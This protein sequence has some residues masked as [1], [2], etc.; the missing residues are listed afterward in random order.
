M[1]VFLDESGDSG[2][3]I[4]RG[5][6]R[7]LTVAIVTF[8]DAEQALACDG[9]I[10]SLRTE[11][12]LQPAFE[13]HFS[14]NSERVRH[15]FL[16]AVAAEDFFY[17]AFSLNKDPEKLWGPGFNVK[18]SLYKYVSRL[19]FENAKPYLQDATVVID[20]SGDRHFR[21]QLAAYLRKYVRGE[22]GARMIRK[23]KIQ[24]SSGNNLLQLA[25]YVAGVANRCV[26]GRPD[27]PGYRRYLA[28]HEIT[29]RVWP[30]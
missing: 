11:L 5:S 22:A 26:L 9:R 10:A 27:A 19:V 20:G 3:K 25:D 4:E 1:L 29:M 13:F 17:H 12:G 8:D 16:G 30:T 2:R 7:Y 24:R 23:V 15:A 6:S 28:A 18:E 14:R 21:D